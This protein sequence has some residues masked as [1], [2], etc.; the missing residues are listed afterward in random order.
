[1]SYELH[2]NILTGERVDSAGGRDFYYWGRP[3]VLWR[4]IK[5]DRKRRAAAGRQHRCWCFACSESTP[6]PPTTKTTT[7]AR[8]Y[9]WSGETTARQRRNWTVSWLECCSWTVLIQC[10]QFIKIFSVNQLVTIR[11][12]SIGF[13]FCLKILLTHAGDWFSSCRLLFSFS[14]CCYTAHNV[15]IELYVAQFLFQLDNQCG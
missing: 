12:I 9:W 2:I 15:T 3:E 13:L 6:S 8:P 4:P 7:A 5:S 11:R 10:F 1:M 14:P